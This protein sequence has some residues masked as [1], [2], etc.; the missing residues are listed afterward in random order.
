MCKNLLEGEEEHFLLLARHDDN[1]ATIGVEVNY[2][3]GQF[4]I[5]IS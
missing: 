2:I 3:V 5:K 4:L 1:I